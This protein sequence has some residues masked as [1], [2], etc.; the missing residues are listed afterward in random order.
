MTILIIFHFVSSGHTAW[1]L[2]YFYRYN[3]II[4]SFVSS[5]GLIIHSVFSIQYSVRFTCIFNSFVPSTRIYSTCLSLW[6]FKLHSQYHCGYLIWFECITLK[7]HQELAFSWYLSHSIDL[8]KFFE[9]LHE[10]HISYYTI[11]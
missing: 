6:F 7:L 9:G 2:W 1:A 11:H 8:L 5:D 3:T 4:Q 10:L